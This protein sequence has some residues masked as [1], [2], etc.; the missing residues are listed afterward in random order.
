M[1]RMDMELRERTSNAECCDDEGKVE[2]E[3]RVG[4]C[5]HGGSVSQNY[6]LEFV[7]REYFLMKAT[8]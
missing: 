2:K 4:M 6:S 3:W 1:V 5:S 7:V 8:W